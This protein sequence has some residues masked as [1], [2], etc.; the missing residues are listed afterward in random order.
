MRPK[1]ELTICIILKNEARFLPEWLEYH[2]LLGFQHFYIY[3]NGSTDNLRD[4]L[5]HYD[6]VITY[7]YWPQTDG[8]QKTAYRNCLET[9]GT[10]SNW[11]AF[12]DADEFIVYS[13]KE[14]L[15]TYLRENRSENGI[16]MQ[17]VIFGTSGH[18][19]RPAGLVI[20]NYTR[21][22]LHSPQPNVKTLCHPIETCHEQ[23]VSP[24]R[25]AYRDGR[26]GLAESIEKLAVYHYV[27]R[28][29]EDLYE[30]IARGDAWSADRTAR[31]L[32]DIQAVFD[33]KLMLYDSGE[34]TDYH[35]WKFVPAIRDRLKLRLSQI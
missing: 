33:A 22:F 20:E 17:W 1:Y 26:P 10:E 16:M 30:K 14:D 13:G 28:S 23:I 29:Q 34:L 11:T 6:N 15:L 35:M 2:L 25:F 24:H 18:V 8:Q 31:N 19:K 4:I 32:A 21:R 12:I 7:R 5:Y 3:D 27:T 9:Y